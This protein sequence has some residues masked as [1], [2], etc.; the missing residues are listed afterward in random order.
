MSED[1]H[2]FGDPNFTDFENLFI[3][4]PKLARIT[5]HLSRFNPIR[6]MKMEQME[7]RHS[8][9]L[10]W[11]L[12]PH[13]SHGLGD[14]F[15]RAF[16]GEALRGQV[17]VESP[18]AL[19]ILRADLR[20]AVIRREWQNIDILIHLPDYDWV[21]VVE[22]K[23]NSKQSA[24][25]LTRYIEKAYSH[26]EP[27]GDYLF[28]KG[29]FLTLYEEEPADVRYMPI[30][31]ETIARLLPDI[32]KIEINSMTAEVEIFLKHY[33]EILEEEL[34]ISTDRNKM[35]KLARELYRDHKTVLD[36]MFEHGSSSDFAIAVQSVVGDSPVY[37]QSVVIDSFSYHFNTIG[38]HTAFF[39]P[40]SWYNGF[41]G[42]RLEWEGCEKHDMGFPIELRLVL[43]PAAND[44][45]GKLTLHAVVGSVTHELRKDL[46]ERIQIAAEKKG[47]EG[48]TFQKNAVLDGV[49][50][51]KFFTQNS[52]VI[53]DVQDAEEIAQKMRKLLGQFQ[54]EFK[55][56]GNL[57]PK[58]MEYWELDK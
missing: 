57:L 9:I 10:T 1:V 45:S 52:I 34:G 16:L 42:E 33:I 22:N 13:E 40:A 15:L 20:G 44:N 53:K 50:S 4:N 31:Y 6:V 32:I 38:N 35:E 19:E 56:I 2:I 43:Q 25:Q 28:V 54:P 5:S 26:I 30:N 7:I 21:F 17:P 49:K 11:L 46:I 8:A 12:T 27:K 29:I 23:F 24:G 3:N 55:L 48:I 41:G 58:F 14:R 37:S 18:T 36:F 47:V 51:S 39:M